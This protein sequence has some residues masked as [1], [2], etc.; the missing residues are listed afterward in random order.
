VSSSICFIFLDHKG[1]GYFRDLV[2]GIRAFSDGADIAWFDSG[3][4][5]VVPGMEDIPRIPSSR[6]LK[7]AKEAPFFFDAFEWA[8][9]RGYDYLV[10]VESDMAFI[11]HGFPDFIAKAMEGRDYL[12]P[13]LRLRTARTS[14]WFPY[15]SLRAEL[16]ELLRLLDIG[17]T[18]ASSNPG[19]VFSMRYVDAVLSAPFYGGLRAFIERN[20]SPTASS[21][22]PEVL[23]PTLAE[24][25]ELPFGDYPE[26]T[27]KYNRYRPYHALASVRR[28]EA[29]GAHLIHPVRRDP[30]HPARQYVRRLA[31]EALAS[32]RSAAGGITTDPDSHLSDS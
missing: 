14:R 11:N 12:A 9:G 25:L 16:P 32:V 3:D 8:V 23:M 6:P 4:V 19:Q 31:A 13:N 21:S 22:L 18:N 26:S 27:A 20:Q 2:R 5:G 30:E 10:N 1:D 7:Y 17:H 15:H 28:A 29:E 24:A